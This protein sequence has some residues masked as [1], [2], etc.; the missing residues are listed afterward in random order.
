MIKFLDILTNVI[1]ESKRYKL[2]PEEYTRLLEL[3]NRLWALRSKN[4]PT[5][6]MVDQ[7]DF[8]TA[9]GAQGQIKLYLDSNYKN[10]A[11]LD[12]EPE[13][14]V[15]PMD[16]TMVLNPSQFNSKK[17][18]FNTLYHEIMHATDPNFST[19]YS[20][21]YWSDYDPV[22]TESY[23]GHPIEFRAVTNEF[24]ESLVREFTLRN[25]RIQKFE[26]K[27]VLLKSL[28][29]I[30]DYFSKHEPLSKTS[31]ELLK[32]MNDETLPK[33]KIG[34]VLSNIP[35]DYPGTA[36]LLPASE[37][38]FLKYINTVKKYNPKMWPRFLTMLYKTAE[39]IRD[40]INK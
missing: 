28:D 5:R 2:Q 11:E 27:R 13:G 6:K 18:L 35:T 15:D 40:I 33:S 22:S 3:S 14:S 39:E 16:F 36:E 19:K 10:Y 4:Y 21:D 1:S 32:R 20:E 25:N 37:P 24:L 17:T 34:K 38:Y 30:L 8:Q 7:M 29:N 31:L 23:W 12:V 9:E 26:N